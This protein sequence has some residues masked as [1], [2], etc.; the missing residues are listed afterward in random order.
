MASNRHGERGRPPP[1]RNRWFS[2]S[3][4]DWYF[5]TREGV[6]FG[7]YEDETAAR[8]ALAVFIAINV[9]S[10]QAN[11]SRS[12]GERPGVEEGIDHMV[13]EIVRLL[14]YQIEL[15]PLGSLSWAKQ[16]ADQIRQHAQGEPR[17]L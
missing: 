1:F 5:D 13:E 11:N 17:Q 7:P 14:T 16:R 2:V 10:V 12:D 15:G 3:G 8:K 6:Q 9:S 4:G